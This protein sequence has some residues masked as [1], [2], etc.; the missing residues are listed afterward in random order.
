MPPHISHPKKRGEWVESQFLTRAIALGLAIS[1]PWG[2]CCRYD[3][4]IDCGRGRLLRVQ[5]K[6]VSY[7]RGD[8]YFCKAT[9]RDLLNPAGTPYRL[10]DVDCF[11]FYVIP[12]DL[13]FI[14]PASQI[15]KV[16]SVYL[17]PGNATSR[18]HRFLEA[19]HLFEPDSSM[20]ST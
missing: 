13:W 10:E 1:K 3:F 6:G 15:A 18:Y 20:Q 2:D 7:R 17:N 16:R 8:A 14:I 9:S 11:A 5:V 19:W 4:I 12:E